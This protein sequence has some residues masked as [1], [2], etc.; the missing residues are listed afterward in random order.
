MVV[1]SELYFARP[2]MFYNFLQVPLRSVIPA[3][4]MY[5]KTKSFSCQNSDTRL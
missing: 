2:A 4:P 5:T 3:R 1:G